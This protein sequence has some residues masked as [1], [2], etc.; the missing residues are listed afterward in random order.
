MK[1]F[2]LSY[3]ENPDV[4]LKSYEGMGLDVRGWL[5]RAIVYFMPGACSSSDLLR[6]WTA[7]YHRRFGIPDK[8]CSELFYTHNNW[9]RQVV[10]KHKLLEFHPKMGWAPLC[11]F[12]GKDVRMVGNRPFPRLNEKGYIAKVKHL[13]MFLGISFYTICCFVLYFAFMFLKNMDTT[14]WNVKSVNVQGMCINQ[15]RN[16]ERRCGGLEFGGSQG[17]YSAPAT[18]YLAGIGVEKGFA[19]MQ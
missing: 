17:N 5:Y 9:V 8:P 11:K 12:V 13:S 10:P 3:R 14:T 7:K 18:G 1:Q 19:V 4:W 6:N 15:T 2:I 16:L